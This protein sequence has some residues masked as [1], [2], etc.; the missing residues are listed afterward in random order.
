MKIMT[1]WTMRIDRLSPLPRLAAWAGIVAATYLV[2]LIPASIGAKSPHGTRM[3]ITWV[4]LGTAAG[5]AGSVLRNRKH[6]E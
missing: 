4:V 6:Q 1:L 3:A 5:Y 2:F